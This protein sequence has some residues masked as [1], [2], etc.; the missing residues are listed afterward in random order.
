MRLKTLS[1]KLGYL[2]IWSLFK[3]A[4]TSEYCS[5]FWA[6]NA[7]REMYLDGLSKKW[8]T[9]FVFYSF[10]SL[11]EEG[12]SWKLSSIPLLADW[13]SFKA[14]RRCCSF[15]K[16]G[17]WEKIVIFASREELLGNPLAWVWKVFIDSPY[18]EEVLRGEWGYYWTVIGSALTCYFIT[19]LSFFYIS[20]FYFMSLSSLVVSLDSSF[21]V[22]V[23]LG[24]YSKISRSY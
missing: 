7:L 9:V 24:F 4:R 23:F 8:A 21:F 2:L 14:P 1:N 20:N 12:A 5:W 17:T 15:W 6:L 16:A 3:L 18:R 22:S 19:S 10:K 13:P 11:L